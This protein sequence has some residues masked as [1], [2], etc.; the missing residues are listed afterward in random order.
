MAVTG[1]FHHIGTFL[2][3]AACVLLIITD[4][5][6]PVV[7]NLAILDV[8]LG[9]STDAHHSHVTFGTFG[10]CV[11]NTADNGKDYCSPSQIGYDPASIMG[12]VEDTDFGSAAADTTKGLTRVMILHP[13]ATGL[14]FLA[15]IL[16]LGAGFLGSLTAALVSAI[17]FIVTIVAL[18]CDFASF[19]IVRDKINSSGSGSDAAFAVAIW[20]ILASAVCSLLGN[21]LIFFTC[22]SARL[23]RRRATRSKGEYNSPPT[24]RRRFW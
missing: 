13:I 2:L 19:A 8:T 18:A 20:T 15:F 3:F 7:N 1:F 12:S 5:S 21:F 11:T 17:T 6:S 4:I 24:R 23:H 22:C 14:A 9:N 10:W 16:A